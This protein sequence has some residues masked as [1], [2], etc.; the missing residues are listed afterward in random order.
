MLADSELILLTLV[1]IFLFS[2]PLTVAGVLPLP[3][4]VDTG[5]APGLAHTAHVRT[6]TCTVHTQTPQQLL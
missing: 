1:Y 3:T 6:H 2:F 4:T 5:H